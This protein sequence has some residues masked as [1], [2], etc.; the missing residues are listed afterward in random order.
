MINFL[1]CLI[2]VGVAIQIGL[3]E[4]KFIAEYQNKELQIAKD[5]INELV[6]NYNESNHNG[7]IIRAKEEKTKIVRW[8]S[9]H[10]KGEF[11]TSDFKP[12]RNN[13]GYFILLSYPS[14]LGK[15]V[16]Q[17]PVSFAPALL[18]AIGILGTFTGIFLGLQ[19]V[20]LGNI[21]ETQQLDRSQSKV[22]SG[23]EDS[24][25]NFFIWHGCCY[26]F[27]LVFIF[28]NTKTD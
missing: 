14:I 9:E 22:V 13:N 3:K 2:I 15:P 25:F 11:K 16:P 21:G 26:F 17:S 24:F 28:W 6:D 8:L 10:L 23:N 27:Y 4:R 18:T 1:F 7:F 19:G 20:D 12:E 5:S